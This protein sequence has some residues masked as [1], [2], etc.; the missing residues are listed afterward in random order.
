MCGQPEYQPNELKKSSTHRPTS[1][2][3]RSTRALNAA[4]DVSPG[5]DAVRVLVDNCC[6]ALV[7]QGA[8]CA[9]N[10]SESSKID[11]DCDF[12]C[13]ADNQVLRL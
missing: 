13:A 10:E 11:V 12:S 6:H 8:T 2:E 5:C 4:L 3:R 7:V 1:R 9:E